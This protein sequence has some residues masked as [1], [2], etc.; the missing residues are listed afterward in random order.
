MVAGV[1]PEG[2]AGDGAADNDGDAAGGD[3][4]LADGCAGK[5]WEDEG[6]GVVVLD[7]AGVMAWGADC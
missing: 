7:A 5:D 3:A 1:A 6:G 2:D 4:L